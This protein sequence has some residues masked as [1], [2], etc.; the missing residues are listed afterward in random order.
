MYGMP[1]N[2]YAGIVRISQI[3]EI[4]E[5]VKE[6]Q[7]QGKKARTFFTASQ[8]EL[9]VSFDGMFLVNASSGELMDE[10]ELAHSVETNVFFTKV[11]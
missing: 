7:V 6:A 9:K 8:K 5:L 10:R 2:Q 4:A 1:G 11:M 3:S